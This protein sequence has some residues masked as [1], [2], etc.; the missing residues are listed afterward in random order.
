MYL[1]IRTYLYIFIHKNTNFLFPSGSFVSAYSCAGS[2]SRSALNDECE[3]TSPVSVLVVAIAV[4]LTCSFLL[5]L[6]TYLP[7]ARTVWGKEEH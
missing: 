7:K 2:F 3:A 4:S 6:F 5:P 1:Y